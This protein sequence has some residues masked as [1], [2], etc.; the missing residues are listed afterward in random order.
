MTRVDRL[1]MK[2]FATVFL[3]W[4]VVLGAGRL[5]AE[6]SATVVDEI[7]TLDGLVT[8]VTAE[9][10][11]GSVTNVV[12]QNG[13]GVAF[14]WTGKLSKRYSI[15]GDGLA[16]T[17]LVSVA[18]GQKLETG[19]RTNLVLGTLGHVLVKRGPGTLHFN[20]GPGV[21]SV[22]TR[23]I[24]EE[25]YVYTGGGDFFGNHSS[26]TAN[27]TIDLR[28]H[29]VYEKD[30]GHCPMGPLE[31]TGG[32][33]IFNGGSATAT[34]CSTALRGGVRVHPCAT[35]S[36]IDIPGAVHLNH[37]H[38]D[39]P[40]VVESGATLTILGT[41]KNGWDQ[42][43]KNQVPNRML[44]SGGGTIRLFG[45]N[46]F[47]GG[48]KISDG[49]TVVA[50][51][52]T[53]FG[54]AE[55]L[56]IEGNVTLEVL[57]GVTLACTTITGSG[58]LTKR[59][60]GVAAFTTV[61]D[62]VTIVRA[63]GEG[64]KGTPVIDGVLHL[65]GNV[66]T[67]DV[68]AD[69]TLEVTGF[70]YDVSDISFT[71]DIVK[72][73]GGTLVLPDEDNGSSFQKLTIKAGVVQVANENNLGSGGVTVTTG[74]LL[75]YV[76]SAEMWHRLT[77]TGEGGIFVAEGVSVVMPYNSLRAKDATFL[78]K[79]AGSLSFK[80][81]NFFTK[82]SEVGSNAHLV[83]DEG[84]AV[85]AQDAFGARTAN[86]SQTLEVHAGATVLATA[87]LPV[88]RIVMRGGT[89]RTKLGPAFSETSGLENPFT[90][91]SNSLS[92]N[93]TVE[94]LPSEDGSPS[95]IRAGRILLA[96]GGVN[97]TVFDVAEGGVL[98]LE[99]GQFNN[100]FNASGSSELVSGFQKI[101]AGELVFD[102]DAGFSGTVQVNEGVFTLGSNGRLPEAARLQALPGTTVRLE[103]DAVLATGVETIDP[104]I[105][106]ADLW[107]DATR[108]APTPGRE[109]A[110]VPNLGTAGGSFTKF[111]S[112]T[113]PTAPVYTNN[114]INGRPALYFNGGSALT[115]D[116]YTNKTATLSIFMVAQWTSWDYNGGNGGLG[117]WGG[118]L[119][120]STVAS[121]E[122]DN[123]TP[124]SFH[125]ETATS[126]NNTYFSAP[127]IST[128]QITNPN[129]DVGTPYLDP[130]LSHRV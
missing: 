1:G 52:P 125:T 96:H 104:F 72:T 119:S 28:E 44:I 106:T 22:P 60:D 59:G 91:W 93:G 105:S 127:N 43:A 103:K 9:A 116:A 68:P 129:R 71:K 63:E 77:V 69:S 39:V 81:Q 117:H 34:W 110:V 114:A 15:A 46:R 73:G 130:L 20:Q 12:L 16:A 78:K 86:P 33:A 14:N 65:N 102:T 57:P 84:T 107:L 97:Q 128:T 95:V 100:G 4:G 2:A 23:W 38:A 55:T 56:E 99:G 10:D 53:A 76:G 109:V 30:S 45:D 92:L 31:M 80:E 32:K 17:G 37:I 101:G 48:V 124:Y 54:T 75:A 122:Q 87:H 11:F 24:F 19:N 67:V 62:G 111:K 42:S 27:L 85:F 36:V 126:I 121:T 113:I 98:R 79:G 18:E 61:G 108:L 90:K 58:T 120:M 41:L 74:G 88:G 83:V 25:G 118:G 64:T 26:T 94:V 70:A 5:C 112:G 89:I 6:G 82:D 49:M 3:A 66:T 40:F 21:V 8:N 35:E 50:G 115:T 47:T 7:L 123:G 29:V 51:S 13:G